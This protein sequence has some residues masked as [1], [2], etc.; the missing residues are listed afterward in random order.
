MKHVSQARANAK[1]RALV[2][3]VHRQVDAHHARTEDQ[4]LSR[5]VT[6]TDGCAHAATGC[7]ALLVMIETTEAEYI[8]DRNPGA[9][10]VARARVDAACRTL[11]EAGIGSGAIYEMMQNEDDAQ[12]RHAAAYHALGIPCPFL[13]AE[14]RCTIYRDRPLAC[15]THFALSPP[16]LCSELGRNLAYATLD[17]G[18]R[19]AGQAKLLGGITRAGVARWRFNTLP[20]AIALVL[21]E[22][23]TG[24]D[25]TP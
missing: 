24:K 3:D 8:V 5:K 2:A 17:K 19:S 7:C 25:A 15:R 18:T 6:C 22:R 12:Y 9:V 10:A 4:L 21:R 23:E 14:R 1:L 20:Q 11:E 13:S 16:A